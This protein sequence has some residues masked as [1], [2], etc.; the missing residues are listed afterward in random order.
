M[1]D[2]HETGGLALLCDRE[3]RI[4]HVL[5]DT[6]GTAAAAPGAL[7]T[8]LLD[9]ASIAKAAEF[10]AEIERDGAARGWELNVRMPGRVAT[11]YFNGH[12]SESGTLIVAA[13]S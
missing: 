4:S 10:V 5:L 2:T 3:G 9:T 1:S 8:S 6:G 13:R 12:G 11:M 7:F